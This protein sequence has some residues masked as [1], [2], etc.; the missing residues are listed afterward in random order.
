M[1]QRVQ[2][3][4]VPEARGD[5]PAGDM[6]PGDALASDTPA[7]STLADR[8]AAGAASPAD[9]RL[10]DD[11]EGLE[12]LR[13]HLEALMR[14]RGDGEAVRVWVAG[15][16]AGA[17]AYTVAMI[18]EEARRAA[19]SGVQPRIFATDGDAAAIAVA[20]LGVYGA[21]A[22]AD[23]PPGLLAAC[24]T[25][26]RHG[27]RI[28]PQVRDRITFSVH[29]VAH[30]APFPRIDVLVC[31]TLLP[32]LSPEA[33]ARALAA[34]HYALR[35]DGVLVTGADFDAGA[36]PPP[37]FAP[38]APGARLHRS[39]G[40]G[41][42]PDVTGR[43]AGDAGAEALRRLVVEKCATLAVAAALA[44]DGDGHVR[45]ALGDTSA[46]TELQ[47]GPASLLLTSIVRADLSGPL[48]RA[49]ART[50]R[51]GEA[52]V[53]ALTVPA[54]PAGDGPRLVVHPFPELGDGGLLVLA[55]A[56]RTPLATV[57]AGPPAGDAPSADVEDL[58]AET[59]ELR[60]SREE[61]RALGDELAT[62]VASLQGRADEL[63]AMQRGIAVPALVLGRDLRVRRFTPELDRLCSLALLREGDPLAAVRWRSPLR[64]DLAQRLYEVVA[65]GESL[66]MPFATGESTFEARLTPYAGGDGETDGIVIAFHDVTGLQRGL[67]HAEREREIAVE[68]LS[69]LNEGLIKVDP[70]GIVEFLNPAAAAM[71]EWPRE[72]AV[73]LSL[74]EVLTLSLDPSRP[75]LPNLA[76]EAVR[77]GGEIRS[78]M[79]AVLTGRGGRR[80]V[81]EFV[82]QPIGAADGH[83][84]GAVL[85]LRDVGER[86]RMVAELEWRGNHDVL[87]GLLNRFSFEREVGRTVEAARLRGVTS[88]L[89]FLDVD[90]F[91]IVN[92]TSGHI[93]G[94]QL[95]R[96]LARALTESVRASDIVARVGGDE[97][98]VILQ[99]C[100]LEDGET[101]AAHLIR[102]VGELGFVWGERSH[103]IGLSVGLVVIDRVAA[104]TAFDVMADAEIALYEAK[105]RG[106]GRVEVFRSG[107]D[108]G[109]ARAQFAVLTEINRAL[110]EQA[111]QLYC[112]PV[113]SAEGGAFTGIEILARLR[114]RGGR[115]MMPGVFL[116]A[117]ERHG[118]VRR[119]DRAVVRGTF[120]ALARFG[121]GPQAEGLDIHIN[122]AG[123]T[124][125][126]RDFFEHVRATAIENGIDLGRIVFEITESAAI[127]DLAV[128][129]SFVSGV[130]QL[131]GRIALD[132]FGKGMSS[133]DYLRLLEIDMVKLDGS[134]VGGVAD[135]RINQAIVRATVDV[136][137]AMKLTLV[138]EMVA[139]QSDADFLRKAG[140]DRLQGYLVAAPEPL[141]DW[142]AR[143]GEGA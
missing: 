18:C 43:P 111:V 6:M 131:G 33:R 29:D 116:P 51:R 77:A 92:D 130:R 31:R 97:F 70:R 53:V 50:R 60:S 133:F 95:L 10:F 66:V 40:P 113:V 32:A 38:V 94:D 49:M 107:D 16:G 89:M 48:R 24:F 105:T 124:L 137:K 112:Q 14:R 27:H 44:I 80:T 9:G 91:K 93:A 103:P 141:E 115:L 123:S 64:A 19:R 72:E 37:A 22:V 136:A 104:S 30:D 3:V 87:T 79:P 54:D 47:P 57:S 69:A 98:A 143:L 139:S 122:V 63:E 8:S 34:F 62:R 135:D 118:L 35:G 13:G 142:F 45:F 56:E 102:R 2:G 55:D 15:C 68:M 71:T 75:R 73:G 65:S 23:V 5:A 28:R 11:A 76:I 4:D 140:V 82:A 36:G 84:D 61:L 46:L 88:C 110:A 101:S 42:L 119:L 96:D 7:A 127:L 108:P 125:S 58:L 78:E 100:R 26:D 20:R 129:R 25:V 109:G 74:D 128:A 52:T 1:N 83:P 21:D 126:D 67:A 117:A 138:A 114:D 90:K 132:D 41:R 85:T 121:S 86:E 59:A 17:E 81:V 39:I 12:A 134:F 120:E 99:N 106:G